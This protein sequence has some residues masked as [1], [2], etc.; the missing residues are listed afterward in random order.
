MPPCACIRSV[1]FYVLQLA[2]RDEAPQ[3]GISRLL[4]PLFEPQHLI[5]SANSATL[6]LFLSSPNE[7]NGKS[8]ATK[9]TRWSQR[10]WLRT[11]TLLLEQHSNL[12][13][14]PYKFIYQTN[15]TRRYTN[16]PRN[17]NRGT[18]RVEQTSAYN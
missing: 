4:T 2:R 7:P 15:T 10:M 1:P 9:S 11:S 16:E 8:R 6:I 14:M 12:R 13:A 3:T 5:F 18:N 17:V